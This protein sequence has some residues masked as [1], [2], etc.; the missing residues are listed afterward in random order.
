VNDPRNE[1]IIRL[2][3]ET[4]NEFLKKLLKEDSKNPCH[5]LKPFRHMLLEARAKDP[6]LTKKP[7]PMLEAEII[8]DSE[9]LDKLEVLF[10]E[11]AFKEYLEKKIEEE[12]QTNQNKDPNDQ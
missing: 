2:L 6:A 10:R 8:Q 7:I 3:R 1:S 5:H 4:K 9:L 12:K 11:E